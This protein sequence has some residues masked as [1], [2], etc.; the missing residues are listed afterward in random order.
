MRLLMRLE[1]GWGLAQGNYLYGRIQSEQGED[2]E[3]LRLFEVSRQ[4]F[5][6][7][8]DWLGVAKNLNLMAVY[9]FKQH[10]DLQAAY[11]YLEQSASLQRPLPLS[12]TYVETLRYLGRVQSMAEA[13]EAAEGCLAEA[14]DASLQQGDMGEYSAVLYEHLLLCKKRHQYD[15]ALA[16]G[17]ECLENFRK[18]GSLRWEGLVKTQL[19]LLHQAR[20]KLNEALVLFREGLHIFHELGDLFEQAYSYY[21]LY[22]LYDEMGETG[23]SLQAREDARRLNLELNN[24]RLAERLK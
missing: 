14:A 17:Y 6:A 5:E 7:E 13:Y 4:L 19:A 16:F 15:E 18:L 11:R 9:Q 3:A 1:D 12:S 20:Q 24:P 8:E 2:E 22:R 10:H 23:Q 21:Y